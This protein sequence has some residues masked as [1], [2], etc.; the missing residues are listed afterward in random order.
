MPAARG[1]MLQ[2][3]AHLDTR[4]SGFACG[5]GSGLAAARVALPF[6]VSNS[7]G[8]PSA[9][10]PTAAS[11][12]AASGCAGCGCCRGVGFRS[13][14]RYP[15]SVSRRVTWGIHVTFPSGFGLTCNAHAEEQTTLCMFFETQCPFDLLSLQRV[16]RSRIILRLHLVGSGAASGQPA[17]A[18]PSLQ[19][20][21]RQR[22]QLRPQ[23]RVVR[24]IAGCAAAQE[25]CL[26]S[27]S[28]NT[29]EWL[30]YTIQMA[31]EASRDGSHEQPGWNNAG[32]QPLYRGMCTTLQALHPPAA[33]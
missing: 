13:P 11:A 5:D 23:L 9:C 27:S 24:H 28:S 25:C 12:P 1:L 19:L 33:R 10:A 18:A 16:A 30:C 22:L 17:A 32:P 8:V 2:P 21:R 3:D 14:L 20:L 26:Q 31:S 29:A 7:M 4:S 15:C 6:A